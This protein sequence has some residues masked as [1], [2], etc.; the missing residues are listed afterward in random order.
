MTRKKTKMPGSTDFSENDPE[1]TIGKPIS[2]IIPMTVGIGASAGGHEALEEIIGCLHKDCN[3]CVV[4]VMHLPSNGPSHLSDHIRRYASLPVMQVEDSCPLQAGK[5]F[6]IPPGKDMTVCNGQLRLYS[7]AIDNPRHHPIDLFFSSLAGELGDLAISVILSGYGQDGCEGVKRVNENGG[8]VLIQTPE[9]AKNPAM[10]AH[11]IETGVADYILSARDIGQK[12]VHLDT[13]G[14]PAFQPNLDSA[15]F[16]NKL[17]S[18]FSFL[19]SKTGHDFSSYKKS[20][21]LRRIK[22]RMIVC[23]TSTIKEYIKIL[24]NDSGEALNLCKNLL[25]GVTRFFRDTEAFEIIRKEI[26]PVLFEKRFSEEPIRI[27]HAGCASGEEAYSIAILI[28]EILEKEKI[29]TGVKIFATDIDEAALIRART[30]LFS[31][32]IASSLSE[33]RLK[34]FF[35]AKNGNWQ[36]KPD[37][38]D[39]IVFANHSV[40]KDPPFSKLDLLVCRNFM[41]YLDANLQKQLINL[42]FRAVK[43][44][45][46]LFLG[47]AET[48]GLQ[49]NLF[50]PKDQKWKIFIRQEGDFRMNT[51]PPFQ[52]YFQKFPN[53]DRPE[54]KAGDVNSSPVHLS[55]KLLLDRYAPVRVIVNE[56]IEVI[57]FSEDSSR[58]LQT[59]AG[60]PTLSLLKLAR[61][62]LRTAL[63]AAIYKAFKNQKQTVFPDI[64][65]QLENEE[66]WV[67][68]VIIPFKALPPNDNLA[69]V[70]F[71]PSK[72]ALKNV[73][74]A[75]VIKKSKVVNVLAI[76][77]LEEEL[78]HARDQLDAL[79]EQLETSDTGFRS[80]SEELI[81]MVEEFQSA[82]EE[83]QATNEELETSKEELQSLNEEL[84]TVNNELQEK[85]EELNQNNSDFE[86]LFASSEIAILFL[87][88]NL[89]LKRFSPAI[90]SI[91]NLFP[92]SIG[93]EIPSVL[94]HIVGSNLIND[95]QFVLENGDPINRE[96]TLLKDSR[97]FLVRI[98]PYLNQKGVTSGIV[99][100]L[101]DITER[102][103]MESSLREREQ[104]LALFIDQAPASLAMFDNQMRYLRASQ[105]WC[106]DY[107][108]VVQNLT[109]ISHYELFPEISEK[110]KELHRRGLAGEVLRAEADSFVRNDGSLQWLRWEIRPWTDCD[111]RIGGI[112]IFS[113]DITEVK[114]SE[115]AKFRLAAIVESYE[116]AIIA[117]DMNDII[118]S[119]NDG[120]KSLYGYSADEAIGCSITRL[121]PPELHEE[122][123]II[124]QLIFKGEK[125]HQ[126]ETLRFTKDGKK[127]DV[128]LTIS[129]IKDNDGKIIGISKIARNITAR[130]QIEEDLRTSENRLRLALEATSEGLWDWD[131]K[132]GHIYRSPHYYELVGRS[133]EEDKGDLSFFK[134][135][136]HPKDLPNAMQQLEDHKSGKTNGLEFIYQ[137]ASSDL[138][139]WI[140]VKGSIVERASDGSPLRMVGTLTDVTEHQ[141]REEA[142]RES[143]TLLD[144]ALASM[145]DAIFISD[146]KGEFTLFNEAFANFHRFENKDACLKRLS[147]YPDIL[148]ISFPNGNVAPLE[149]W[150][151][152]R[153]LR[154]E[155]VTNAVYHLR[156]K[157]T[158]A[159]WVGSY[160]FAP[161]RDKT[162]AIVGSV[163]VGR[164]ISKLIK[165]E[166]DLRKSEQRLRLAQK[167]AQSGTWEWDLETNENIWSDELFRL[168]GLDKNVH[169]PSFETFKR[170][171]HPDDRHRIEDIIQM[172][173]LEQ[174]ELTMEWRVNTSDGTL[175]WLFSRGKPYFGPKGQISRYLGIVMD[176]TSRKQAEDER[177]KLWSQLVQAQKMEAIGTLAGGI[178]HDF[179]N[180]LGA[181]LG[182]AELA[183]DVS[184]TEWRGI[185]DLDQVIAAGCR[186][187]E[188]VKQ[189]LAFSR[190]EACERIPLRP[191]PIV[192]EAI[193]LIRSSLPTTIDIRQDLD[194]DAGALLGDPTQI[195][196]ITMN[197]CTNAY[198]AMEETGGTLSI[199][200]KRKSL[201]PQDV[202]GIPDGQPGDFLQLTVK[203]TGQGIEPQIKDRIFEPYFTTKAT[204]KGTG[205]GL[206]IIHGIIKSYQGF[207]LCQSQ[208]GVG[209]EFTV[210]LPILE[211]TIE[212][213]QQKVEPLIGGTE[214]ILV[215]DDEYLL[216]EMLRSMLSRLG[217]QVVAL[218]KTKEALSAFEAKPNEFDMMITDLTM[219]EMTGIELARQIHMIR[220]DL[221]IIL[222]TGYSS[223][224]SEEQARGIGIKG[225][226]HK[227]LIKKE[228]ASLVRRILDETKKKE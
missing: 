9:T 90:G 34:R 214:H 8:L 216:A 64:K 202:K 184:P 176:I 17:R 43:P 175:R 1:S 109:G 170:Q 29:Q 72:N 141:S 35:I 32:D 191:A 81:S 186:A 2:R 112:V 194:Q 152:P 71:E 54:K 116:D 165:S 167:A 222:C 120:A 132:T 108:L 89:K 188:L 160:S 193:K 196:Q 70:I 105:K 157:D 62:E 131:F 7:P 3:L 190:Q 78:R 106:K 158:G 83:L 205:M 12:L 117:K 23:G 88:R 74:S 118:F 91:F 136:V 30:G 87:D 187:K 14:Y 197:L 128:S 181:I 135:T 163:V 15:D 198:H 147:E 31:G 154:G 82:N 219:P 86:N 206:A 47:P 146:E 140:R 207:I 134:T 94:T 77:Q 155:V 173:I 201:S 18:L 113:E 61:K 145:S 182:Y 25:I 42:F 100:T 75:K 48:V 27:W 223:V 58:F 66:T 149:M 96:I 4:V 212:N 45:R 103:H 114:K 73:S 171:V 204:G 225:F 130:K 39:M 121:I 20:T 211:T 144:A 5:I 203:D 95:A 40:I 10:P 123:R 69:L 208:I 51:C 180:I 162:G 185:K 33:E 59:P 79:F 107:D 38:R 80:A 111:G 44:G 21:V 68:L 76:P 16:E 46:F 6:V 119:W 210:Y 22:K 161:I 224:I 169:K 13:H 63:R 213:T 199:S 11:A 110:W 139:R 195:H 126:F 52:D 57:Y 60:E 142:L 159:T 150:A 98:L 153:A 217:Y 84:I 174:T 24:E 220:P 67:N 104:Q 129:P 228:F 215:V 192:K 227:P 122:E 125:S 115:E 26:I 168:Y 164:D 92:E 65:V 137:L 124:N 56:K 101:V 41:I 53:I 37:L 151:V 218:S 85:I 178:A 36:V 226:A 55:E 183:R 156:R 209:T 127:I 19:R 189:I 177:K 97:Y 50:R 49:N 148:E 28:M 99:I 172:A 166:E 143:R 93:Q 200:L 221:P 138:T 133:P 102:K 179:N